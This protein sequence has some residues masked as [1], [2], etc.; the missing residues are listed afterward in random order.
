[1]CPA[2]GRGATLECPLRAIHPQASKKDKPQVLER[3]IPKHHDRICTQSSVDFGP[4]DGVEHEQ[5]LR[6]GSREWV[7][8]YRHDRNSNE[9]FHDFVKSGP[10][11]LDDA[12]R[13]RTRGRTAQQFFATMLLVSAN[14]RKIARFR[15]EE[16]RGLRDE[17]KRAPS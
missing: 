17:K 14:L 15:R 13:R 9:S 8:T 11:Q 7:E 1:M 6:Y 3:N 5:L 10:E 4:D 12:S 16:L 2:Y